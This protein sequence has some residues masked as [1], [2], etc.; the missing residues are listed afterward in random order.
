MTFLLFFFFLLSFAFSSFARFAFH[1]LH[2]ETK[3]YPLSISRDEDG[4]FAKRKK[5]QGGGSEGG[6]K[7]EE[8]EKDKRMVSGGRRKR[9]A[10]S[11]RLLRRKERRNISGGWNSQLISRLFLTAGKAGEEDK[12]KERKESG[13]GAEDIYI[14]KTAKDKTCT[15]HCL[16]VSDQRVRTPRVLPMF[17]AT[18]F[19]AAQ[20]CMYVWTSMCST[21]F[22][23][24][25][26]HFP[27][28]FLTSFP[29]DFPHEA[30]R[31]TRTRRVQA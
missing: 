4:R 9:Q 22:C 30:S 14:Y 19:L 7:T 31:I 28:L 1:L 21:P 15:V 6:R 8:E 5:L 16:L 24:F 20:R 26:L 29:F 13:L 12:K 10:E 11:K 23:P 3:A 27:S 18:L 2:S 17:R 25:L